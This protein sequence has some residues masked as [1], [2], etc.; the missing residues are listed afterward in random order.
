[1]S[2]WRIERMSIHV[3]APEAFETNGL[4]GHAIVTPR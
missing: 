4:V 1:M 3:V 2:G